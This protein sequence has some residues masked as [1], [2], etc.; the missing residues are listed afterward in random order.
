MKICVWDTETTG[1]PVKD[2]KLDQQPYIIQF[3]AIIGE[4]D[5]DAGTY[6][7]LER[8]NILIK[9]RITIPFAS[10]QVHGIYD[11]DV[12]DK[13]YINEHIDTIVG[14]LNRVDIVAGHNIS[15][16]EEVLSYE[17]ARLGRVGEYTPTKTVCTM[18]GSTEY[19]KLQWRGFAFKPPK[20]AELH[21]FLFNEWFEWAHDAMIDVEATMRSLIEL[22]R[23]DVVHI[24]TSNV[25]RLF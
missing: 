5:K 14:I 11:K 17:L 21:K 25:M 12:A 8:Y 13:A 15:F 16:D 10:S 6:E 20:L 24:E 1:F 23:R 19:C 22:I 9:P 2:G 7:E 4:F 3:A 18:K